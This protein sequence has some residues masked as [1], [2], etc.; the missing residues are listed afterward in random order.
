[1][2]QH[3][4]FVTRDGVRYAV[5]FDVDRLEPFLM[6]LVGNGDVWVFAG[7]TR[8]SPPAA[9]IPTRRSSPM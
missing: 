2:E 3:P 5:I 1:M 4:A 7:A 6:H 9:S 8:R